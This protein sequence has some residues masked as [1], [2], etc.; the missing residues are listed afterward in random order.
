MYERA[1]AELDRVG[2]QTVEDVRAAIEDKKLDQSVLYEEIADADATV[3]EVNSLDG[4]LLVS[5]NSRW[6]TGD[7]ALKKAVIFSNVN[8]VLTGSVDTFEEQPSGTL[9]YYP[10]DGGS[11]S[12]CKQNLDA[13]AALARFRPLIQQGVAYILPQ[14]ICY[15]ETGVGLSATHQRE[16]PS[17]GVELK[18]DLAAVRDYFT[19]GSGERSTGSVLRIEPVMP[20]VEGLSLD[21]V[22]GLRADYMDSYRRFHSLIRAKLQSPGIL[23]DERLFLEFLCELDEAVIALEERH[24]LARRKVALDKVRIASGVVGFGVCLAIDTEI[25]KAVGSL[26]GAAGVRDMIRHLELRAV[27][28]TDQRLDPFQFPWI[29]H[30]R[31]RASQGCVT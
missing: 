19:L 12:P 18:F 29:V 7:D 13:W 27:A 9:G 1:F 23:T 15:G 3:R 4:L 6:P 25:A 5:E 22:L 21:A 31:S 10:D 24:R 28:R 17:Q 30:S 20:S 2:C 26:L 16:I 11:P 8:V 14:H